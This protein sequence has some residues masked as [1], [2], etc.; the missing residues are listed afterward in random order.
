MKS[1]CSEQS[2]RHKR[3]RETCS[4]RRDLSPD[5]VPMLVDNWA[6]FSLLLVGGLRDFCSRNLACWMPV[7]F[8]L[9]SCMEELCNF[10]V[11]VRLTVVIIFSCGTRMVSNPCIF[12]EPPEGGLCSSSRGPRTVFSR[13][14]PLMVP[15]HAILNTS[16]STN[17]CFL[18]VALDDNP[19]S[20]IISCGTSAS[21]SK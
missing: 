15:D 20:S 5:L 14:V 10:P 18:L 8:S 13:F 9:I 12:T 3:I 19:Q 7:A 1:V 2:I 16:F 6:F 11:V 4:F 17:L 21:C